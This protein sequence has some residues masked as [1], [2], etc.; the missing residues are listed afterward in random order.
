MLDDCVKND[1]AMASRRQVNSMTEI[2]SL[3]IRD[4]NNDELYVPG[5]SRVNSIINSLF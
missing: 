1:I 3:I 4:D 2:I 5:P